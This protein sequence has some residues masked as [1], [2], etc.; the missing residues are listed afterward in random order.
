MIVAE[1]LN[2]FKNLRQGPVGISP[3]E[4]RHLAEFLGLTN[5]EF[6]HAHMVGLTPA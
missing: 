2:F 6:E 5:E 3:D 1:P 4:V